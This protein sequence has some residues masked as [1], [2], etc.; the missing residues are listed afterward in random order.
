MLCGLEC[1]QHVLAP[2]SE[3]SCLAQLAFCAPSPWAMDALEVLSKSTHSQSCSL[4]RSS[5]S[6]SERHS[7]EI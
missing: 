3:M 2:L 5:C 1:M 7:S 4:V 6:L